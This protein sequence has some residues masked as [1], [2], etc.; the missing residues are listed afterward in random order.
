MDGTGL[1]DVRPFGTT[2]AV[3]NLDFNHNSVVHWDEG[4]F[5][6]EG[7]QGASDVG[8]AMDIARLPTIPPADDAGL[9]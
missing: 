4:A 3:A 9:P 6:F 2:G 8:D 5:A 7:L 1:G